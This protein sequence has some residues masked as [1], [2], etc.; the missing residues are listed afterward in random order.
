MSISSV[1]SSIAALNK[2]YASKNGRKLN[3]DGLASYLKLTS[4][5]TGVYY[6]DYSAIWDTMM[7]NDNIKGNTLSLSR[8]YA[9]EDNLMFQSLNSDVYSYNVKTE[10]LKR[11][12]EE[13]FIAN[14]SDKNPFTS[15]L[16]M[17][18][19]SYT[20]QSYTLGG[21]N[22]IQDLGDKKIVTEKMDLLNARD[23]LQLNKIIWEYG[24]KSKNKVDFEKIF[25]K[26]SNVL[27][28]KGSDITKQEMLINQ[29]SKLFIATCSSDDP[30]TIQLKEVSKLK[31]LDDAML[32]KGYN[33]TNLKIEDGWLTYDVVDS[34]N[35]TI[36]KSLICDNLSNLQ[37]LSTKDITTVEGN[38]KKTEPKEQLE[39]KKQTE[40]KS[41]PVDLSTK[42]TS[43][44]NTK[45]EVKNEA[46]KPETKVI[47]ESVITSNSGV[48]V[49]VEVRVSSSKEEG[50]AFV[51]K[52]ISNNKASGDTSGKSAS[53]IEY[54]KL[55]LSINTR[56]ESDSAKNEPV[57]IKDNLKD[58]NK[59]LSKS[60]SRSD[61]KADLNA[62]DDMLRSLIADNRRNRDD[63][64]DIRDDI[65]DI[66]DDLHDDDMD[67]ILEDVEEINEDV[68]DLM[69]KLR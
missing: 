63:I 26:E 1:Q 12:S 21:K 60:R 33:A 69:R 45:S 10:K 14:N 34:S 66:I 32:A 5:S 41:E 59:S 30:S 35:N 36:L 24:A 7:D 64:E 58:L 48:K 3:G 49:K 22:N 37:I 4:S 16:F 13:Q 61:I 68:S 6:R 46:I 23:R 28:A 53:M 40:S 57:S 25:G 39:P 54:E 31:V 51:E 19:D 9:N 17:N 20:I 11:L 52:S 44:T 38:E 15:D 47:H 18:D 43:D 27:L 62:M 50:S 67:D 29:G 65:D 55:T 42:T 2:I 56:K 8:Y